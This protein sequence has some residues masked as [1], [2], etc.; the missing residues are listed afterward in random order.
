MFNSR[1]IWI[2]VNAVILSI[3][4]SII[5]SIA[6][7]FATL[8]AQQYNTTGTISNNTKMI[9]LGSHGKSFSRNH[10]L[11]TADFPPIPITVLDAFRN[12]TK[13]SLGNAT[14]IAE[15]SV[16]KKSTASLSMVNSESGS[17]SYLVFVLDVN[18]TLHRVVVDPGDGRILAT[19]LANTNSTLFPIVGGL[20]SLL[21]SE[22]NPNYTSTNNTT[23][24]SSNRRAL[25]DRG[26]LTDEPAYQ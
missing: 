2:L 14:N 24:L 18:G 7:Q 5:S 10:F 21:A 23:S 17:L 11:R 12:K 26:E 3:L 13:I 15:E 22:V 6:M 8:S 25:N 4:L 20:R 9:G 16:G 1:K 19:N